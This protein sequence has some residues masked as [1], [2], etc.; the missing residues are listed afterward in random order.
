[1]RVAAWAAFR[2]SPGLILAIGAQNTFLLRQG[3][4]WRHLPAVAL[5]CGA[6]DAGLIGADVAGFGAANRA[7]PGQQRPSAMQFLPR[8][9]A[10]PPVRDRQHHREARCLENFL[11]ALGQRHSG[12][13]DDIR[14]VNA[15][16]NRNTPPFHN[17]RG[18]MPAT[19]ALIRQTY[20]DDFRVP[21]DDP[22]VIGADMLAKPITPE[23]IARIAAAHLRDPESLGAPRGAERLRPTEVVAQRASGL[24]RGNPGPRRR[25]SCAGS[26][27][28]CAAV[29]LRGGQR[30]P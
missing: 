16:A 4:R 2:L 3:L 17:F 8:Q 19:I 10:S 9:S 28:R 15:P 22:D 14:G 7:A 6:S 27:P 25:R 1:M 11:I 13:D 20:A 12:R 21:G 5:F 18:L 29:T 24:R 23:L 26:G 30:L